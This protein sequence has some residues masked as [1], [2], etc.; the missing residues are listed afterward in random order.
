MISNLF[1]FFGL[2]FI[3]IGIIGMFRL[4]TFQARVMAATLV[5][6]AGYLLILVGV[7]LQWGWSFV[8]LKILLIILLMLFINPL[9]THFLVQSSWKAGHKEDVK[10]GDSDANRSHSE[11]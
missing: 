6:T 8:S 10:V 2:I 4:D 3:L 5:D 7:I 1:F 11:S 9:L